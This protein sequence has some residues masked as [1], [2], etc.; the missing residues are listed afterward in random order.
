MLSIIRYYHFTAVKPTT[1]QMWEELFGYNGC[2]NTTTDVYKVLTGLLQTQGIGHIQ[3]PFHLRP[4]KLRPHWPPHCSTQI[5]S[6]DL[7]FKYG[8]CV[9]WLWT[10]TIC[11]WSHG[12][13]HEKTII[14][15]VCAFQI[16]AQ[17]YQVVTV[18]VIHVLFLDSFSCCTC[19]RLS[20]F[21]LVL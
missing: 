6:L 11:T 5:S 17:D 7:V 3:G 20:S 10:G 19:L 2:Y 12:F 18:T 16:I 13:K 1:E 15:T 14:S 21:E 4:E 8:S 9:I